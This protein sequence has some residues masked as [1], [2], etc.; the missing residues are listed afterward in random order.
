MYNQKKKKK[1][2]SGKIKKVEDWYAIGRILGD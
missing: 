1:Y 2:L